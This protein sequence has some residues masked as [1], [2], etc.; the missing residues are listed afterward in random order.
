[1]SPEAS[2]L[3]LQTATSSPC[4]LTWL[5]ALCACAPGVSLCVLMSSSYKDTSEIALRPTITALYLI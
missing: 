3:G 1:M 4:V 5:S 2:L